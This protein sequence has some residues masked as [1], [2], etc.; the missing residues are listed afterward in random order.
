M[1]ARSLVVNELLYF[2][3]NN[4][5]SVQNDSFINNVSEFYSHDDITSATKVLKNE[6][7]TFKADKIEKPPARGNMKSD[8]LLEC[9]WLMKYLK[10]NNLWNNCP[11]FVSAKLDKIPK[12]ENFLTINFGKISCEIMST[13]SKQQLL[14]DKAIETTAANTSEINLLKSKFNLNN[15]CKV[16]E[17]EKTQQTALNNINLKDEN[18]NVVF[19]RTQ[20]AILNKPLW[21]EI[22]QS[23]RTENEEPFITANHNKPRSFIIGN[24]TKDGGKMPLLAATKYDVPTKK[25]RV[26]IIGK[27]V[28]EN[29]TFKADKPLIKKRY[30]VSVTSKVAIKMMSLTT[31]LPM[32]LTLYP[33]FL[34]KNQ[35]TR[36]HQFQQIRTKATIQIIT[37]LLKIEKKKK[38]QL[39]EFALPAKIQRR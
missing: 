24:N 12:I 7:Y 3:E 17:R 10:D 15:E 25:P 39:L 37:R 38:Q 28:V 4:W 5:N 11:I 31:C 35:S 9:I 27:K 6:I 29:S 13:L 1:A 34:C 19:E 21:S 36:I 26:K 18:K 20:Q 8:K 16:V 30:F 22:L 33:V 32:V 23:P 2:L 14:L